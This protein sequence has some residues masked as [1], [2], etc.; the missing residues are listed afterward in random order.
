MRAGSSFRAKAEVRPRHL[1]VQLDGV[2]HV[3]GHCALCHCQVGLRPRV[4][5]IPPPSAS[6]LPAPSPPALSRATA[7]AIITAAATITVVAFATSSTQIRRSSPY[8]LASTQL[9][10]EEAEQA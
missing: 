1:R 5:R 3:P 4:P 9:G 10:V 7:T 6:P 8:S 2:V